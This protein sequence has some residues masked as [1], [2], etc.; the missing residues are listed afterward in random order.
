MYQSRSEQGAASQICP[1]WRHVHNDIK[2]VKLNV[3]RSAKRSNLKKRNLIKMQVSPRPQPRCWNNYIFQVWCLCYCLISRT[4][5]TNTTHIKTPIARPPI[6][7]ITTKQQIHVSRQ[8]GKADFA[9][10][11]HKDT[12]TYLYILPLVMSCVFAYNIYVL[13]VIRLTKNIG[14][15]QSRRMPADRHT[16]METDMQ[17]CVYACTYTHT[18]AY[19]HIW[20]FFL[21]LREMAKTR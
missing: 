2:V 8:V 11:S 10:G 16:C 6:T 20:L 18:H 13:D 14:Q 5:H 9:R 3:P 12:Q 19:I 17:A 21:W 4:Q 1:R 7:Q 15:Y